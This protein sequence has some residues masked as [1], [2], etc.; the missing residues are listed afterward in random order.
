MYVG[1]QMML[2]SITNRFEANRI[3]ANNQ[4]LFAI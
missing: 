4:E 2:H 1:C 3:N